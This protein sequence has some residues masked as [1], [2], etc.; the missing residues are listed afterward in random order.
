MLVSTILTFGALV[1][2]GAMLRAAGLLR[3]EDARPLNAVI[4]Y[5][6]LPAFVFNAVHGARLESAL[7]RVVMVSWITFCFSLAVALLAR[8]LLSLEPKRA[9]G[10]LLAAS[11]GNTG[12][13]GYPLTAALLGAAALPAAVFFDVFGTVFALVLVGLPLAARLGDRGER[14]PHPVR[15][16]LTFPAVIA[17]GVGL[18]LRP[19]VLPEAVSN[20]LGLL[21]SMVAP[22]IMLSVGLSL[23]PKAVAQTAAPLAV[24]A[25]VKLVVAPL[26]A[27]AVGS[28]AL[29]GPSMQV[30]VLEAGMPAMMLTYVVG[31]RF[32]L[33]T[34]FIASAIFVTTL[35][36]ALTVPLLQAV[37][38]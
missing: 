16:L 17:L 5:A 18:L 3:H 14:Y 37:A 22:L 10:F 31:E 6:G 35:A 1:G 26:V 21:A 29:S 27:L 24:L 8:R 23:R 2:I 7:W 33:D 20:G 34:E 30:S 15:E 19:V 9:G 25:G 12:Y 11:L 4:I 36:S 38:F 32:G 28:W 13:V